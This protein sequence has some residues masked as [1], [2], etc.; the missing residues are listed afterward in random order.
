MADSSERGA[1][2]GFG[3]GHEGSAE[4]VIITESKPKLSAG[5]SAARRHISDEET[6]TLTSVGVDIGSS[7]V[8]AGAIIPH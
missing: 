3:G 7:T 1:M 2:A 5:F 4:T 6:L 8:R